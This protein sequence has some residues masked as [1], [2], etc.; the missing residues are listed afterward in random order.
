MKMKMTE[1]QRLNI[2]QMWP[3]A[4]GIKAEDLESAYPYLI[5]ISTD[6]D[7]INKKIGTI[8]DET[9]D[10]KE[11]EIRSILEPIPEP[12]KTPMTMEQV[13]AIPEDAWWVAN[14]ADIRSPFFKVTSITRSRIMLFMTTLRYEEVSYTLDQ[15][16]TWNKLEVES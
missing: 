1:Q 15:G 13:M 7:G 6:W 11:D 14:D 4:T 12:V 8:D 10:L 9:F 16:K 3:N 2:L 5:V